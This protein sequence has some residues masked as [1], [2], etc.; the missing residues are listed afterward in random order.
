[1]SQSKQTIHAAVQFTDIG[2]LV[3]GASQGEGLGR[4]PVTI[5]G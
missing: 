3:E 2:G 4:F 1:M 5:R